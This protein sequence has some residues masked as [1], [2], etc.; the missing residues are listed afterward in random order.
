M[1]SSAPD[2]FRPFR[3]DGRVALITGAASG[4]GRE[5]AVLFAR[6]GAAVVVC[7]AAVV[8]VCVV[9][10]CVVAAVM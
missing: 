9:V 10:G 7:D 2:L 5:A 4:I 8:V 6:A 3:L 1:D